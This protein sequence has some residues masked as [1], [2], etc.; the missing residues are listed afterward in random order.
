MNF[1]D[2]LQRK[3]GKFYIKNLM[4]YIV[5]ITAFVYFLLYTADPNGIFN[6]M[7]IPQKVLKGEIWRLITF[8]FIPPFGVSIIGLLFSLYFDYLAGSGLEQEWG[9]FKFNIYYFTGILA[10]IVISFLTGVPATGAYVNLSLFLAF[11]MIYPNFQV[12]FL[13]VIPIKIKYLAMINWVLIAYGFITAPSIGAKLLYLAPVINFLLFFG[14]DIIKSTKHK[15]KNYARK[16]KY[17][18][19]VIPINGPRHKCTVCGITELDDPN[20]EFRYCSKCKGKQCYCINHIKN[21]KHIE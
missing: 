3:F 15:G 4:L 10:T 6:L 20:M 17:N 8:V 12:L 21:H 16:Q 9:G 5:L 2:K 7:L 14:K 19:K 1:L 18:A 11:A 13:F